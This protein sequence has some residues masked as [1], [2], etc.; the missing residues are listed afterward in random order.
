MIPTRIRQHVIQL[1]SNNFGEINF[2]HTG[3]FPMRSLFTPDLVGQEMKYF[4]ALRGY[5]S[6]AQE[7]SPS[8]T[9][10]SVPRS[11]SHDELL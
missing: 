5:M 9:H 2:Q 6:L 3:S 10:V 4:L 8:S 11:S 7:L 1:W